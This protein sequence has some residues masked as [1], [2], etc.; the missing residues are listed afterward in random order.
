MAA[1]GDAMRPCIAA[2]VGEVQV[3]RAHASAYQ[4]KTFTDQMVCTEQCLHGW[5]DASAHPNED[6]DAIWG[7]PRNQVLFQGVSLVSC[8]CVCASQC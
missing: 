1:L 5:R 2:A 3:G 6:Q 4:C 8:V 7:S